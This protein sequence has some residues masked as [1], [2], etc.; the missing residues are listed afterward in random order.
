V[1]IAYA[2]LLASLC[3]LVAADAAR[4]ADVRTV[5]SSLPLAGS[6][7]AAAQ[8]VRDGELLALQQAGGRV[9]DLPVRLVSLDSASR[10]G[11]WWEPSRVAENARRAAGDLS[12][13]AYIGEF[14]SGARRSPSPC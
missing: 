6:Q 3:A 2:A 1:R 7:R 8:D 13:I 12:T 10:R 9:G 4:A 5:Y 14:N 11:G